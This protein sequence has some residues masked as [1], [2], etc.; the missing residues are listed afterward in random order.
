MT[1]A[2]RALPAEPLSTSAMKETFRKAS[3]AGAGFGPRFWSE[4]KIV[5][6]LV[7]DGTVVVPLKVVVNVVLDTVTVLYAESASSYQ[8]PGALTYLR[9]VTVN[10]VEM[11]SAIPSLVLHHSDESSGKYW[12]P[13]R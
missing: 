6:V 13:R 7:L 12:R 1:D 11:M 5:I 10:A 3:F 4:G 8:L 9:T 2:Y